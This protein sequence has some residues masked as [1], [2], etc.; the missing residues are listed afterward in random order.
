M[1]R[2]VVVDVV[3]AAL[4]DQEKVVHRLPV[5]GRVLGD[6]D[7]HAGRAHLLELHLGRLLHEADQVLAHRGK[8]AAVDQGEGQLDGPLLDGDVGV[9]QA[10]QDGG[11]VPLD[12]L[13][14]RLHYSK[15]CVQGHV[16][17]NGRQQVSMMILRQLKKNFSCSTNI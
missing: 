15:E 14:V 10:V 8:V 4:E 11:A 2:H 7:P 12:S 6:G 3:A 9:L 5:A 1:R 16:P 17:K 13:R